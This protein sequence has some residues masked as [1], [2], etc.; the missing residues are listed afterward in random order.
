MAWGGVAVPRRGVTV[1]KAYLSR[2]LRRWH[3]Y[4]YDGVA[5]KLR[6][7]VF[8]IIFFFFFFFY[9]WVSLLS[10]FH[11]TRGT[12]TDAETR[13]RTEEERKEGRKE[14]DERVKQKATARGD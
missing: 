9:F 3:A 8:S 6:G 12:Q 2:E 7:P 1:A 11:G 13:Q 4:E 10:F 14:K 5:M